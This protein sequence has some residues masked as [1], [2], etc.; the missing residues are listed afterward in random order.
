[1]TAD[2]YQGTGPPVAMEARQVNQDPTQAKSVQ[3]RREPTGIQ[4]RPGTMAVQPRIEG[5][6]TSITSFNHSH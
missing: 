5:E 1:M 6:N 2:T 4:E 3:S